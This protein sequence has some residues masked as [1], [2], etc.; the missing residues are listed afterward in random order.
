MEGPAQGH[1]KPIAM[2]GPARGLTIFGK[3]MVSPEDWGGSALLGMAMGRLVFEGKVYVAML[4]GW[5]ESV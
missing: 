3:P 4:N 1:V 2:E 5:S